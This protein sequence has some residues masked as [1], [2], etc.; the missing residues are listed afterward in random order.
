MRRF[1]S[2]DEKGDAVTVRIEGTARGTAP[3]NPPARGTAPVNPLF[4]DP[5]LYSTPVA[6]YSLTR[7]GECCTGTG[8][9]KS[10]E[11]D[12]SFALGDPVE[13]T[14]GKQ[15]GNYG[16]VAQDFKQDRGGK[17][18]VKITSGAESSHESIHAVNGVKPQNA[19]ATSRFAL[20]NDDQSVFTEVEDT[21]DQIK[22]TLTSSQELTKGQRNTLVT[23]V[24]LLLSVVDMGS[25]VA[26]SFYPAYYRHQEFTCLLAHVI[27]WCLYFGG[28]VYA[29]KN[30]QFEFVQAVT[31]AL[32]RGQF[33]RVV[34]SMQGWYKQIL[35]WQKVS[36]LWD[37]TCYVCDLGG[38]T[39]ICCKLCAR[40]YHEK[41]STYHEK[42]HKCSHAP[43]P[44]HPPKSGETAISISG[45][46]SAFD[47]RHKQGSSAWLSTTKIG[48]RYRVGDRVVVVSSGGEVLTCASW[49]SVALLYDQ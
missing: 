17:V 43:D 25:V 15:K 47:R 19:Y 31:A 11:V 46:P 13:I 22:R 16:L 34:T 3:V 10:A 7:G 2:N 27:A 44:S 41:C 30:A 14:E 35:K 38:G 33:T 26:V 6:A 12:R 4:Q 8:S 32:G 40:T 28:V 45:K 49:Y 1:K 39:L 29:R 21:T 48:N 24:Q 42:C 18:R 9:D 5:Y 23:V 36:T 20:Q 37:E